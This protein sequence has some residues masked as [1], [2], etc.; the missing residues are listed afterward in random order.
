MIKAGEC[1]W[2][3]ALDINSAFWSIPNRMKDRKKTAFVTQ[4]GHWQWTCLLFGLKISPSI[5]QRIL[6][7][8]I[9]R[10]NLNDFCINYINDILIFSKTFK[11]NVKHI[12]ALF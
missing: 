10:H 6:A 11:Q 7:N 9:R 3:S 5:F 8:L 4:N 12:E 1:T 2:F